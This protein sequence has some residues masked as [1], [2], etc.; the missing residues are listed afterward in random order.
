MTVISDSTI[1]IGLAKIDRLGFLRDIFSEIYIPQEVFEEVVN[2]A[3][4]KPGASTVKA[5]N[6]IQTK[7]IVDVMQVHLLMTSLEQGEAEVLTLAKEM[8]ADLVLLDEEK[9][10]KSAVLAGFNVMG[11]HWFSSIHRNNILTN[12]CIFFACSTLA[13]CCSCRV[14]KIPG[15]HTSLES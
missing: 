13:T 11:R 6:W 10:R 15:Y 14:L 5:C 1:L 2:K 3:P 12:F 4:Q 9:A 7:S 8:S